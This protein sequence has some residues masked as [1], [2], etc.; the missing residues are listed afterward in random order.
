MTV[1]TKREGWEIAGKKRVIFLF[2]GASNFWDPSWKGGRQFW[3]FLLIFCGV[4]IYSGWFYLE[5]EFRDLEYKN[6]NK[7]KPNSR[8]FD[9]LTIEISI[10][11]PL[12]RIGIPW[13][14]DDIVLI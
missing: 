10:L 13:M 11:W 5:K 1:L 9:S 6:N 4:Y 7:E 8:A 14:S 3:I 12:E 2:I